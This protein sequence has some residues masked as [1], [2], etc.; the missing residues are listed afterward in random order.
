MTRIIHDDFE[1]GSGQWLQARLGLLT[2]STMKR[3]ITPKKLEFSQ[4]EAM[5]D[6]A[7][8]LIAQ[9]I[10]QYVSPSYINDDML[11]GGVEEEKARALYIENY[12]PVKQV[13]FITDDSY[14]FTLGFSP[15]GLVG[16]DGFIE[17]K[18]RHNKFQISTIIDGIIPTEFSLQVQTGFLVTGRK[19]CDFIS[20]SGGMH[21]CVIRV[22]PDVDVMTAIFDAC[23]KFHKVIDER[24]EKYQA[25]LAKMERV[26][27]LE[28]TE[29]LS[30][31]DVIF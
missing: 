17:V 28:R 10:T 1:Q 31:Q 30:D 15:D 5:R 13:G 26:L 23:V 2:A 21:L 24:T 8:E 29:I 4:S 27:P 20:A 6:F 16:E 22:Y 19:W 3:I 25:A 7:D 11:R 18:S 14:G 9:R 12:A